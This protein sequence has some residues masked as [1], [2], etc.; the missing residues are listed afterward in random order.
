MR[1]LVVVALCCSSVVIFAV[2]CL[3][4]TTT[5]Y[6]NGSVVDCNAS[7]CEVVCVDAH[8]LHQ[9]TN[10]TSDPYNCGACGATCFEGVC[11][12]N[13]CQPAEYLC[14]ENGFI[15]CYD[16]DGHQYCADLLDDPFNCGGCMLECSSGVCVSGS[17]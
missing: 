4:T 1:G 5:C 14:E 12:E 2:G 15:T 9:C 11:S 10:V 7:Y 17:C 13:I 16:D 3:N 8:G 6:Y